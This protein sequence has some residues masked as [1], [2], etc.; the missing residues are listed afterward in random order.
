VILST[1]TIVNYALYINVLNFV[2]IFMIIII[3][4]NNPENNEELNETN[5][6]EMTNNGSKYHTLDDLLRQPQLQLVDLIGYIEK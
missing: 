4:I 3:D 5:A 2:F 1:I 6:P